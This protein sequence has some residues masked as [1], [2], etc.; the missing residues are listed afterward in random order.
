MNLDLNEKR[1]GDAWADPLM[2]YL[3][4]HVYWVNRD[5]QGEIIHDM[6]TMFSY[7][8]DLVQEFSEANPQYSKPK[9]FHLQYNHGQTTQII[10]GYAEELVIIN[11]SL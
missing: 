9:E 3:T 8:V 6:P 7:L 11:E 2:K 5:L 1:A 10:Y 4:E